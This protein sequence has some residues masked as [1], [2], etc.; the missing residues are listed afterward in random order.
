MKHKL[1]VCFALHASEL[2]SAQC[3]MFTIISGLPNALGGY[4][5]TPS[6]MASLL[7]VSITFQI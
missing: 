1:L 5:E 3:L 6:I 4:D 7:K 2:H